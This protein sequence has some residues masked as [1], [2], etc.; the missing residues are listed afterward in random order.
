MTCN[1]LAGSDQSPTSAAPVFS[2]SVDASKSRIRTPDL[3]RSMSA[4]LLSGCL[5]LPACVTVRSG[6]SSPGAVPEPLGCELLADASRSTLVLLYV[7]SR[8]TLACNPQRASERFTPASTF[9]IPHALLAIELG[10]VA[11]ENQPIKWD[12]RRRG[13]SAWDKD[14]TLAKAVQDSTVWVFQD[15]AARLEYATEAAGVRRLDYGNAD[16]GQPNQLRNFWLSGPLAISAREQVAFLAKLRRGRLNANPG[17]QA[18]T[19]AMLRLRGC[20][21]RCTVFG[22]T[23]AVLPIDDEGTLRTGASSLLPT[24]ERTG[25]FVGWVERPE[26]DGGPVVFAHNLDLSIAGAMPGR[27]KVA[28]DI[29]KANGIKVDEAP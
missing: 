25:W 7:Q 20:G 19:A 27:T 5:L 4:L 11:D 18:R 3:A 1:D 14:T 28:Y 26:K 10:V 2:R 23:G 12:G 17:S 8:T 21:D 15:L 24:G 13:V 9:K 6:L 29:L 16:V 22:K